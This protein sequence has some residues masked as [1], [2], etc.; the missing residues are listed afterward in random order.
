MKIARTI[1]FTEKANIFISYYSQRDIRKLQT[2]FNNMAEF[3]ACMQSFLFD[4]IAIG[5]VLVSISLAKT[6]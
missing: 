6:G 5:V 3:H 1:Y 2:I 4:F